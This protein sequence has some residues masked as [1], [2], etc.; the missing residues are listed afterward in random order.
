MGTRGWWSLGDHSGYDGETLAL[1]RIECGFCGER[2]NWELSHHQER[3]NL[4][5]KKLNYDIYK[6]V[7]CGNLTMVFW[8]GG[9]R[10]HSYHQVPWPQITTSHPQH[11]PAE[12]GRYWLQ[13][14][15]NIEA[16]NWDAAALMARSAL[17]LL[18]RHEKAAGGTLVKEIDD[19]AGKGLIPPIMKKWAHSLRVLGNDVAH[20]EPGAEGVSEK[21]ARHVV[22]FLRLLLTLLQDLPAE[23]KAFRGD[24][25]TKR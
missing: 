4:Q 5:Q 12:V 24:R 13:A 18:F 25:K 21:D 8:S 16:S 2:G 19:L 6:C 1:Y 10:L 22:K 3:E 14:Q 11:W 23:I 15:R 9:E 7:A 20:P 17:Q